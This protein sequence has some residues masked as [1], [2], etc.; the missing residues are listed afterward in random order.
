MVEMRNA[1]EILVR[2]PT[3]KR[4]LGRPMHRWNDNRKVELKEI[5]CHSVHTVMN[6]Q[7]P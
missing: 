4:L 6:I 5:G 3:E 7:I 1:C 2:K